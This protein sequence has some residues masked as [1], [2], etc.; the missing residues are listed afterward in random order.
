MSEYTFTYS[1]AVESVDAALDDLQTVLERHD[2]EVGLGRKLLLVLS[3][4]ITN[5]VVHGNGGDNSKRIILLLAV[6]ETEIVAD[7]IDQGKDGIDQIRGKAPAALEAESGRGVDLMRHFASDVRFAETGEGGLRVTIAFE[8][9]K[10]I[11]RNN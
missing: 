6:N 3:E 8:I 11:V 5:A 10:E 4:A 9:E 1:S 2:I 7:I